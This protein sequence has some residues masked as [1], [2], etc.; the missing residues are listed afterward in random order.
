MT[1][2]PAEYVALVTAARNVIDDAA[3]R[4]DLPIDVVNRIYDLE[5]AL[6]AYVLIDGR[7]DGNDS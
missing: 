5:T 7:D 6:L 3:R 1:E 2:L 4:S